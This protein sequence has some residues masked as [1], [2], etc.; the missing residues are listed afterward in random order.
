MTDDGEYALYDSHRDKPDAVFHE[1]AIV[2]DAK[3]PT[4][5]PK[6]NEAGI[7]SIEADFFTG[8]WETE[9]VDFSPF[10]VGHAEAGIY[11]SGDGVQFGASASLWSPSIS[12]KIPFTD[13]TIELGAEIGAV[14]CGY[15]RETN[16]FSIS[17]SFIF[18]FELKIDW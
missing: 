5:N 16:S 1:Q 10:D 2:V 12:V 14:G 15:H 9:Y 3:G 4:Y 18:G 6:T 8:G 13:V 17:G 7:G 11:Y